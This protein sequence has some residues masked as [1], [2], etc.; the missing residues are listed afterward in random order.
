[1]LDEKSYMVEF[2]VKYGN[3]IREKIVGDW[4]LSFLITVFPKI[5]FQKRRFNN[6][7]YIPC[8]KS[9]VF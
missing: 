1:M 5:F 3:V 4:R 2:T 7:L 9:K 6:E 8:K